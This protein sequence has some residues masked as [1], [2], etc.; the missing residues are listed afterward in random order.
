MGC[1]PA[2]AQYS[3]KRGQLVYVTS[4]NVS[5]EQ[6]NMKTAGGFL[7]TNGSGEFAMHLK[8][9]IRVRCFYS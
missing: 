1:D 4:K 2:L 5:G 9:N 3:E 6:Q 8:V 7:H